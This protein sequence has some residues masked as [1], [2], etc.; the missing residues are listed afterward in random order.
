VELEL[1]DGEIRLGGVRPLI[2]FRSAFPV[3]TLRQLVRDPHGPWPAGA[4]RRWRSFAAVVS[5]PEPEAALREC[6]VRATKLG[7]REVSYG[8]P[9]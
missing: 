1:V 4:T 9:G 8:K 5:L 3:E 7:W 6:S 2:P